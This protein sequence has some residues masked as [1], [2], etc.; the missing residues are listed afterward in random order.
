MSVVDWPS[1]LGEGDSPF[2]VLIVA[3]R[4]DFRV[5]VYEWA[6]LCV[7]RAFSSHVQERFLAHVVT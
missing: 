3:F 1:V 4:S 2:A 5:C 6:R 7:Y